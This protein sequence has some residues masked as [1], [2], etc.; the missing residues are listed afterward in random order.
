MDSGMDMDCCD[1]KTETL[2][3]DDDFQLTKHTV[4]LHPEYD[5]LISY[6]LTNWISISNNSSSS[7]LTS[8]DTGPP[9]CTEPLYLRVQSFLL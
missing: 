9:V 8:F 1:E 2:V 4:N 3:V 5:L 6:L 7:S